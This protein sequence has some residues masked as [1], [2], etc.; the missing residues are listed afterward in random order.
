MEKKYYV[1]TTKCKEDKCKIMHDLTCCTDDLPHIPNRE[2]ICKNDQK[3]SKT[4]STYYLTADEAN[5][6]KNDCRIKSVNLDISYNDDIEREVIY[7]QQPDSFFN[8]NRRNN[9]NRR[10][11]NNN[12]SLPINNFDTAR[13]QKPKLTNKQ[14]ITPSN[15]ETKIRPAS[16]PPTIFNRYSDDQYPIYSIHSRASIGIDLSLNETLPL[17]N[18]NTHQLARLQQFENPWIVRGS[19]DGVFIKHT[20]TQDTVINKGSGEDVDLI[21]IDNGVW[22]GHPE[23]NSS[24]HV[25]KT[26][27]DFRYGNGLRQITES[28][29]AS[30]TCQVL[31]IILDGPALLDPDFFYGPQMIH[32]TFYRFDGTRIPTCSAALDWWSSN[33]LSARSSKYVSIENGGTATGDNNF[34]EIINTDYTDLNDP[35]SIDLYAGTRRENEKPRYVFNGNEQGTVGVGGFNKHG[36]QCATLAYGRTM[37]WAYNANKWGINIYRQGNLEANFDAIT[38]F[39]KLKPT[40]QGKKEKNPTLVTSSISPGTGI[41]KP[42]SIRFDNEETHYYTFQNTTVKLTA[43]D[44]VDDGMEGRTALPE[45]L[46]S[47]GHITP[48]FADSSLTESGN[49][50]IEAG[51]FF[52]QASKNSNTNQ[53]LPGHPSYN[54]HWHRA[55][56]PDPNNINTFTLIGDSTQ[57]PMY[58]TSSRRGFPEQMG[59]TEQGE[60]PVINVGALNGA[61]Y[62]GKEIKASYSS[63][64]NGVDVYAPAQDTITGA[65][66]WINGP[67]QTS[68]EYNIRRKD[69]ATYINTVSGGNKGF[70]GT[71]AATPV[72]AGFISTLIGQNRNWTWREVKEYIKDELKGQPKE[73]FFNKSYDLTSMD[74]PRWNFRPEDFNSG[75]ALYTNTSH[76]FSAV[77]FGSIDTHL[78]SNELPKIPYLT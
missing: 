36:T 13:A 54:N 37:G 25:S 17:L 58:P 8:L 47:M 3:Y 61:L 69:Q 77:F 24:L 28:G 50:L 48:E 60:Y 74:D 56:F 7:L 70:S 55:E 66:I 32:K 63:N 43:A 23:F 34:G 12:N 71:S 40:P 52:C 35:V 57:Q 31:D 62:H 9:I 38:V 65:A 53:V 39:H 26:P 4:R 73:T 2:C 29:G 33:S 15:P 42:Q 72:V 11:N 16:F 67:G 14:R 75:T 1:V 22:H 30:A 45:Y 18:T 46:R 59:K 27:K 76:E 51:V 6:L 21:V 41:V 19:G 5:N 68:I 44:I 20:S 10:T 78:P 64:G 49:E